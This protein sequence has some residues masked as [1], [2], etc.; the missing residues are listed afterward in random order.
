VSWHCASDVHQVVGGLAVRSLR[1]ICL[2]VSQMGF[3]VARLP[4]SSEMIQTQKVPEG[5]IDYKLNPQLQGLSPLQV[6]DQVVAMLGTV[7]VAVVLSN[8]A[9]KVE[10]SGGVDENGLWYVEGCGRYT[11]KHWVLDWL[12]MATQ[13]QDVKHVIGYDLRSKVRNISWIDS[14]RP[15]WGDAGARDWACAARTCAQQLVAG[16]KWQGLIIIDSVCWPQESL[17]SLLEPVPPWEEWHIPRDRIV[18]SLH[19]YS[20]SGPG[21]LSPTAFTAPIAKAFS[22]AKAYVTSQAPYG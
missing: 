10:R 2:S 17:S 14:Q 9:T 1:N 15:S 19:M 20:W 18:V 8:Q 12:T 5:A 4:F 21:R 3:T 7:G 16:P 11:E 22:Y 13:Y 6:L